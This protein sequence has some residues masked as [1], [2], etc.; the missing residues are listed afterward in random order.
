M[1]GVPAAF[2]TFTACGKYIP[3]EMAL[4]TSPR[5]ICD[6]TVDAA[7]HAKRTSTATTKTC[8]L[9]PQ[10]RR[11]VAIVKYTM[12]LRTDNTPVQKA[13]KVKPYTSQAPQLAITR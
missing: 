13:P 9:R 5:T 11:T 8:R 1:A 6:I 7:T 2:H 3:A 12:V 10:M 4:A